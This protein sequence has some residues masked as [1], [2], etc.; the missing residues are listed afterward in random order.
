MRLRPVCPQCGAALP[1]PVGGADPGQC[2]VH[3]RVRA[4]WRAVEASYEAFTEHLVLSRGL[5]TW[6]PWPL[7]P[8]WSVT[9][10]GCVGGE[11]VPPR[12]TFLTC[13]G[14][15]PEDGAVSLT[16]ITEEP[17][18]GLGALLAAVPHND[19]GRAA[20]DEPA[21]MRLRLEG[22]SVSLWSVA[23]TAAEA[24]APRDEPRGRD[25]A[26]EG[27]GADDADDADGAD[28]RTVLAGEA[29]GRWLWVV[30]SPAAAV[31]GLVDRASL[32]DASGLGP[33]L[34]AVTF[35][36]GASEV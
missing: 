35:G 31:L 21:A 4:C 9:D 20:W 36:S 25:A 13:H 33:E 32:R 28:D 29:Q 30:V 14:L 27:A 15:T 26:D 34:V 8:G 6:L 10:F 11:G 5:P 17:R 1:Q 24:G 23:T 16:V 19:P 2:P 22:T 18:V 3:G 7:P 12:A